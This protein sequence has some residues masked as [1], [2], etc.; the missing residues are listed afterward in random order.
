MQFVDSHCHLDFEE[1]D[2]DR[3]EVIANAVNQGISRFVIPGIKREFWARQLKLKA[4][5]DN[6]YLAFG[7]HPWFLQDF[8]WGDIDPLKE[9]LVKHE[10]VAVGE[11]GVDGAIDDIEL[12]MRVFSAQVEVANEFSLP[13]IVHH[14]RSH[15]H[16]LST[17][18]KV[19]PENGGIIHA[20]SGS[21]HDADK[22]I[23]LGFKL[24]CGGTITY[25]RAEKTR[26]VFKQLDLEH[27]VLETDCPT[28]PL[29]GYQGQ[30]NEPSRVLP[31]AQELAELKQVCL[32]EIATVT[33]QNI[34][35]LFF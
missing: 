24:G 34:N 22:Y 5:Y 9:L 27:I 19:K 1:F 11:C 26:K 28:M 6:C 21:Q 8:E 3:E 33:S 16:I 31:V 20:F 10:P 29:Y 7:I 17:F 2:A 25:P 12:Q 4:D 18:K 13:L 14:R 15:H 32:K 23:A 35:E 30:R